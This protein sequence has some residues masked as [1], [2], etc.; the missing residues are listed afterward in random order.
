MGG[1]NSNT[2]V[3]QSAQS[4][5]PMPSGGGA[6]MGSKQY[7][8]SDVLR[9]RMEILD[10]QNRLALLKDQ[11]KTEQV[12]FNALLNRNTGTQVLLTDTLIK[13]EELPVPVLAVADSMMKNNPMLTP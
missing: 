12:N 6:S 1:M 13:R 5:N 7:G 10:Q 3:P 2:Q 11:L 4:S 9:I 8:L